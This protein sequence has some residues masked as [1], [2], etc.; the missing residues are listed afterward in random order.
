M[1][2]SEIKDKIVNVLRDEIPDL[3]KDSVGST[4]MKAFI[5]QE[6]KSFF[7]NDMEKLVHESLQTVLQQKAIEFIDR[8]VNV[9]VFDHDLGEEVNKMAARIAPIALKSLSIAWSKN[10]V[11][12][13]RNELSTIGVTVP[14]DQ[15]MY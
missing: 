13:L 2:N 7:E 9:M 8:E 3:L 11:N 4:K 5:N 1:T 14:F 6:M 15:D 12:K 10:I